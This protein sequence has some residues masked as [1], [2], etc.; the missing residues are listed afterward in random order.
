[1]SNGYFQN[2]CRKRIT[3]RLSD[4]DANDLNLSVTAEPGEEEGTFDITATLTPKPNF[5]DIQG[6]VTAGT[7]SLFDAVGSETAVGTDVGPNT[8]GTPESLQ[9]TFAGVEQT[10]T[11][12]SNTW[13]LVI[14]N[15][16]ITAKDGQTFT[17]PSLSKTF[18]SPL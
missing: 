17:I 9:V 4:L 12:V 18:P 7:A 14:A 15:V 13:L 5:G 1:M 3:T 8:G 6:F 2:P 11:N 16:Q 10:E